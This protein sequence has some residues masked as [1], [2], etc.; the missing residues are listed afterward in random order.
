MDEQ[1]LAKPAIQDILQSLLAD[2]EGGVK[3]EL[4][5]DLNAH[6]SHPDCES[7]KIDLLHACIEAWNVRWANPGA[8]VSAAI[9]A[10]NIETDNRDV[11]LPD[12]SQR[13]PDDLSGKEVPLFSLD[14]LIRERIL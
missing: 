4:K 11:Y 6:I 13:D 12:A 5:G 14:G 10:R 8:E 3:C 7:A 9:E 2:L 1:D